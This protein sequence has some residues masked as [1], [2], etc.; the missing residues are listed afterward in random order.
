MLRV[1]RP[2]RVT[3][4]G[5]VSEMTMRRTVDGVFD[6]LTHSGDETRKEED[7]QTC[8]SDASH[9]W[10][11]LGAAG[12]SVNRRPMRARCERG[13][14]PPRSRLAVEAVSD[15]YSTHANTTVARPSPDAFNAAAGST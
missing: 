4:C 7:G 12:G 2:M 14:Y 11:I 1:E 6:E 3:V 8:H 9:G 13:S 15:L 10:V 5:S